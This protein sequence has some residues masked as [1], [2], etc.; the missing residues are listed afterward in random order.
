MIDR[1]TY[2]A[3][4]NKNLRMHSNVLQTLIPVLQQ[5]G[6]LPNAKL[7]HN[8]LSGH[9]HQKAPFCC[10]FCRI[11]PVA[12]RSPALPYRRVWGGLGCRG[13]AQLAVS[14]TN[15]HRSAA[16]CNCWRQWRHGQENGAHRSPWREEG[17][18][19]FLHP[20]FKRADQQKLR[21]NVRL[22]FWIIVFGVWTWLVKLQNYESKNI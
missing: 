3:S 12:T 2:Y 1:P 8:N 16:L 6:L 15:P 14:L 10:D 11:Q 17:H 13:G 20:A 7:G 4:T 19:A 21:R 5:R 9:R 22:V 18:H